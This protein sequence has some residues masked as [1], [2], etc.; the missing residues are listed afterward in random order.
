MWSSRERSLGDRRVLF[1]LLSYCCV[2]V[3][4]SLLLLVVVVVVV[5]IVVVV[6][7]SLSPTPRYQVEDEGEM[8][9]IMN[10]LDS[11]STRPQS[12]ESEEY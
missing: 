6:V 10:I 2:I 9:D 7:V 1:V 4:L 11:R 3:S 12:D 8:F 5:V